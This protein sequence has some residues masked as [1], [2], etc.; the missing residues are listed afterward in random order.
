[1]RQAY[2]YAMGQEEPSAITPT[3]TA[4]GAGFTADSAITDV[5]TKLVTDPAFVL[6]T[7]QIGNQEPG[8]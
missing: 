5:F 8:Q 6:R 2:R 3:L 1:V 4:I 7:T